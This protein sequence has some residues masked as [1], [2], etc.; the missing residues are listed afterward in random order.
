MLDLVGKRCVVLDGVATGISVLSVSPEDG[1]AMAA[2]A[3]AYLENGSGAGGDG[4]GQC[5]GRSE[6]CE[7]DA[8]CC[9]GPSCNARQGWCR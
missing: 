7:S 3:Y 2:S 6:A 5:S 1:Q 4:G 8:G 9:A